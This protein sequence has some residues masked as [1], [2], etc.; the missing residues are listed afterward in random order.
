MM[1]SKGSA[2][3]RGSVHSCSQIDQCN[4]HKL[5]IHKTMPATKLLYDEYH[6]PCI[7]TALQTPLACLPSSHLARN[8]AICR[9]AERQRRP[10]CLSFKQLG[11]ELR[12]K[13]DGYGILASCSL[14][15]QHLAHN[16]AH[17]HASKVANPVPIRWDRR[18]RLVQLPH[19]QVC[20]V[21]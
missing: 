16:P 3:A 10:V 15:L 4:S 8:R 6:T 20:M 1:Y 19:L 2:A 14:K 21:S 17:P 11:L 7:A 5:P 12:C 13:P 9:A 18:L